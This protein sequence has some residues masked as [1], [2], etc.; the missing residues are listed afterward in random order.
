MH[1]SGGPQR[2]V[3]SFSH[4]AVGLLCLAKPVRI[5]IIPRTPVA[6]TAWQLG[7]VAFARLRWW[8]KLQVGLAPFF[9]LLPLATWLM[10]KSLLMPHLSTP[11]FLMKLLIVQCV[12]GSWPSA[13]DWAYAWQGFIALTG[14]LLWR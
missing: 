7:E 14:C 12:V 9:L 3:T 1:L 8:N 2:P 4:A 10:M 13:T 11:S 6:G 5:S